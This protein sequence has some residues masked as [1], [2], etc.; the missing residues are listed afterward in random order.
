[1]R[2]LD[3]LDELR[4]EPLLGDVREIDL[5]VGR[6]ARLEAL[7][8]RDEVEDGPVAARADVGQRGGGGLLGFLRERGTRVERGET[9]VGRCDD[10][11]H[12]ACPPSPIMHFTVHSTAGRPFA[13]AS[14]FR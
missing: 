14:P 1:M 13:S 3:G 11:N 5:E 12:A 8:L 6:A 4:V 10:P 2:V 7:E 9:A